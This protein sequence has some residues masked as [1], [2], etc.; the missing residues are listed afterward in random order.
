MRQ[1]FF[2]TI[3]LAL[4]INP[5]WA[6]K[7]VSTDKDCN[8]LIYEYSNGVKAN[9]NDSIIKREINYF[10]KD[11]TAFLYP[12]AI[13]FLLSTGRVTKQAK[14]SKYEDFDVLTEEFFFLIQDFKM[15]HQSEV[16]NLNIKVRYQ[17]ESGIT[18]SKYP[19][20]RAVLKDIEDFLNNYP[21]KVDYW[22][23]LNKKLTL[24]VLKKYP[25]FESITSEIQVSPSQKVAYLRSSI[26]T[27][28][29]SKRLK[30]R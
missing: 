6:Q 8:C 22:E 16:N 19:D 11:K 23:I 10:A 2:L 9:S 20:F 7:S 29:Q 13:S 30:T 27:R 1:F 15:A 17:Y 25:M 12:A 26:V 14:T 4:F 21:N 5:V 18:E 24:M 3:T 28:K